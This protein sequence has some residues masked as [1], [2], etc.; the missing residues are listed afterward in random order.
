MLEA[1]K[2]LALL[3]VGTKREH[4]LSLGQWQVKRQEIAS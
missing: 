2:N 4:P 3:V 1:N